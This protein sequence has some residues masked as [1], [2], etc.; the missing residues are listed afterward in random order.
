MDTVADVLVIGAGVS[1]LAAAGEFARQ[2]RKVVVLERAHGVG[3]RCASKTLHGQRVDFGLPF[4]HGGHPHFLGAVEACSTA[5]PPCRLLPGWPHTVNQPRLACQP[6]A[7]APHH[8]RLA[9]ADGVSSFPKFLARSLDVR[10]ETSISLL[11]AAPGGID[12]EAADGRRFRAARVV[13]GLAVPQALR[14]LEPLAGRLGAADRDLI[15][16]LSAVQPLPCLTVVA[17]YAAD[18][19]GPPVDADY[20]VDTTILH[21]LIHD[22]AKRE[23]PRWRVLVLQARPRYSA[24]QLD[25]PE[26]EWSR[27]LIWEAGEVLGPWAA[28]AAWTSSHRWRWARLPPTVGPPSS[29]GQMPSLGPATGPTWLT[30]DGGGQLGLCGDAFS[31]TGGVEGSFL[32]GVLL[33]RSTS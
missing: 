23:H 25:A 26:A 27:D 14:L 32:S 24:H 7:F 9:I 18:S 31:E 8:R 4:L 1:G 13:L 2:G 22:S 33:A 21:S 20:P 6:A 5:E 28:R 30:V 16:R 15:H 3:G 12:V 17:G 10:T 29:T 19:P 11:H